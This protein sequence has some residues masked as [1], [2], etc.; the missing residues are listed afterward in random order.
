LEE[1][2]LN[3]KHQIDLSYDYLKIELG[4]LNNQLKFY[5]NLRSGNISEEVLHN[6][7]SLFNFISKELISVLDW[8]LKQTKYTPSSFASRV[9]QIM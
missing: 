1:A 3:Y 7:D 2:M 9:Q 6:A 8:R 4:H 5:E